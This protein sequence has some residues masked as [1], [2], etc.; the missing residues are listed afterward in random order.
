MLKLDS[1]GKKRK[2]DHLK[3]TPDASD[4]PSTEEVQQPKQ[5]RSSSSSDNYGLRNLDKWKVPQIRTGEVF[6]IPEFISEDLANEWLE[7][8]DNLDTWYHP[9][10]KVYGKE[11]IQSRSI[12]AYATDEQI[13]VKYSGHLVNLHLEYPMVLLQIQKKVEDFLGVSF[14]HVML[15]KYQSGN[16]YIGKHRDT[17]ENNLIASLSLGA[18]RTFIMSPNKT[19]SGVEKFSWK[20]LNGSILVMGKGVQDNWKH[21]IPKEPS[22]KTKRISLTFR[23]ITEVKTTIKRPRSSR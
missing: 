5:L 3:D 10:L 6:F 20:L 16:E 15:N 14:N 23:Q 9:V 8:L 13:P 12:A 1:S 18:E 2:F 22:V 11:K 17:K 7:S 4:S 21:E 19:L